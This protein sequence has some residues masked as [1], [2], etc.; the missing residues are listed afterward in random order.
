MSF[1]SIFARTEVRLFVILWLAYA[2]YASPAGGAGANR[3]GAL[4]H[5]IVN[6]GSLSIDSYHEN[7]IDKAYYNGHYYLGALPGPSFLGVPAYVVFKGIYAITPPSIKHEASGVESYKK[8]KQADS[9]FY[10]RVDNVEFFLSQLFLNL[11]ALA[12]VSA[13]GSVFLFKTLRTLGYDERI[14]LTVSLLYALG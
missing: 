1:K 11:T 8:E 12:L 9:S 13:L 7:T 3:Y 5:S 10:G 6:E 2:L 14:A 4:V